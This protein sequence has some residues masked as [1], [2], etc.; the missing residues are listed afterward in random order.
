MK[1]RARIV[2][3]VALIAAILSISVF[4]AAYLV[5]REKE[6]VSYMLELFTKDIDRWLNL[7]SE[8]GRVLANSPELKEASL[9]QIKQNL[10][11][12]HNVTPPEVNSLIFIDLDG[13]GYYTTG[14]THDLSDRQYFKDIIIDRKMDSQITNTYFSRSTG[15][16]IISFHEI[17]K[18]QHDKVK[19]ILYISV[20]VE[21]LRSKTAEFVPAEDSL[22]YILG[23]DDIFFAFSGVDG[24]LPIEKEEQI[25]LLRSLG[26]GDLLNRIPKDIHS[27]EN[28]GWF[29][30]V[31]DDGDKRVVFYTPVKR[32]PGFIFFTSVP[33]EEIYY[34]AALTLFVGLFAAL[35]SIVVTYILC[36]R[37]KTTP[38][39]II[40]LLL[41]RKSQK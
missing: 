6:R 2:I 18:D 8:F 41:S 7:Y 25:A 5:D 26:L 32:S 14:A 24:D 36:R 21:A 9:E 40:G 27:S 35:F 22:N 11:L 31:R 1:N 13:M 38:P 20:L 30:Y 39:V 15:K 16:P 17:V 19:G 10:K 4:S 23:N 37:S 34:G 28:G 33:S 3:A 29:N 12:I